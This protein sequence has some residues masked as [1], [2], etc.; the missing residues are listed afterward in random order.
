MEM[1]RAE[2]KTHIFHLQEFINEEQTTGKDVD[3][4]LDETDIFDEFEAVLP[5]EEFPIFVIT[6]LNGFQS[7]A[8][9]DTLLD[10]IE[11]CK[12]GNG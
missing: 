10:A 5:D 11:K 3:T 9:L 12:K 6:V 4:I 1:N 2:L 8:I 7:D